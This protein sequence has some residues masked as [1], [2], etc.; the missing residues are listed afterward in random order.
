MATPQT[1]LMT[2]DELLALPDDDARY[3]LWWGELVEL[4]MGQRDHGL[5]AGEILWHLMVYARTQVRGEVHHGNTSFVLARNPDVVFVPDIAYTRAEHLP[6]R[7][8]GFYQGAPDL[9]VE[10]LSP[11]N[12]PGK[13]RRKVRTYLRAGVQQ[14]WV[15]D[16]D[17]R[18]VTVYRTDQLPRGL[19]VGDILNCG[20]LMPGFELALSDIFV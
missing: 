16:P 13:M 9:V 5:I 19:S 7:E 1:K 15:V 17:R 10:V 3:E 4:P 18:R 6:P 14:V 12:R 8:P 20:E 2:A 11:S